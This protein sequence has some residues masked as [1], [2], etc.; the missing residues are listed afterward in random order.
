[1]EDLYR[2][3]TN[4]TITFRVLIK[5]IH[6]STENPSEAPEK[7][8]RDVGLDTQDVPMLEQHISECDACQ[9]ELRQALELE[10]TV[11]QSLGVQH[12]VDKL[13]AAGRRILR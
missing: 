9:N 1:M 10:I 13:Q 8:L 11:A 2:C 5:Y 7:H 12:R 3:N 6:Y 4:P